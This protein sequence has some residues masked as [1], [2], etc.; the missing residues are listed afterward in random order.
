MRCTFVSV[1][2]ALLLAKLSMPAPPRPI[3]TV[4]IEPAAMAAVGK[5]GAYLR[6]LRAFEVESESTSEEVLDDGLKAQ[7]GKKTTLLARRPDRLRAEVEGANGTSFYFFNGKNF[8][9]FA[10]NQ[11]YYATV[12]A[13][14][15][16]RELADVLESKYDLQLPLV[17]LFLW[18]DPSF[19]PPN[20]TDAIDVGPSTAQGAT[21]EQYAFRQEGLDW[22]VWIQLGD[23]P[24]PRKMVLTT[25]TDDARPQHTILLNWNLAPS[26][27]EEAFTFNPPAGTRKIVFAA[28]KAGDRP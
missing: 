4:E 23:F 20:I 17:D 10:R 8:T 9:L 3:S 19:T 1:G 12:P 18:G 26:Y 14:A 7:N 24:L 6:T 27:N 25:T 16:L 11:G 28:Q 13:P 2:A 21:C 5:M 15:T 22:Q